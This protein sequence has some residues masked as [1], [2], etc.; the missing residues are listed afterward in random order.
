MKRLPELILACSI[1]AL[2][3]CSGGMV[4]GQPPLVGISTLALS[5]TEIG[6]H[7]A[8][9][10]PNDIDFDVEV[11]E[12]RMTLG[13]TDLGL[14]SAWPGVDIHPRG[15]E[16]IVFD[17]PVMESNT[18][19]VREALDAL[20]QGSVDSVAYEVEGF[21]RNAQ[22]DSERFS[23]NGYLYPVPGRPGQFRGAGAKRERLSDRPDK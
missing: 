11:V 4:R 19:R 15:T 20:E 8:V 22:G 3:A 16:E 12:M 2:A 21:I 17:F 18:E 10:N 6:T 1:L 13:Q 23:H 14:H 7:L 9:Y 5:E